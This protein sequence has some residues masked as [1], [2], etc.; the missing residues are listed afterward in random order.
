MPRRS[1]AAPPGT[2]HPSRGGAEGWGQPQSHS[3]AAKAQQLNAPAIPGAASP[4]ASAGPELRLAPGWRPRLALE[5]ARGRPP[6]RRRRLER[7]EGPGR[8]GGAAAGY[9]HGAGL[10]PAVL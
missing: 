5:A 7:P 4:P 9:G 6:S 8:R 3:E 10:A 1:S 2:E